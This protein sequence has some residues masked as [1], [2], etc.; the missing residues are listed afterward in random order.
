MTQS[1]GG[2][3]KHMTVTDK[4]ASIDQPV[5]RLALLGHRRSNDI[6]AW[7]ADEPILAHAFLAEV[8]CLARLLPDAR[9]MLNGC[10]DR[11]RFAVAMSAALVR[12]QISVLPHNHVASTLSHLASEFKGI[13][14]LTDS[15]DVYPE[16]IR[17]RYPM[18]PAPFTV[19]RQPED[20]AIESLPDYD[21]ALI[22][23]DQVAACLFT[24]GS[25]GA[26]VAHFRRWGQIVESAQLEAR[27]LALAVP[28][29]P[30]ILGTV[31][32]QHSYGFESTV[33]LALQAGWSFAAERPFF[34]ADILGC[35]ARLPRP[36]VLVTTPVHLRALLGI[37]H[38]RVPADLVL[39]AT[40]VLPGELAQSV[41]ALFSAPVHE[42]YGSTE[43]GQ[44][45]SR[46]TL[47]GDEWLPLDGITIGEQDG[48]AFAQ[49]AHV[50]GRMVLSDNIGLRAGGRFVLLGR[51]VDMVNIAGKRSSISFLEHQL[52]GIDGVK[53][54]AFLVTEDPS[55]VAARVLA[56]V[57]APGL[58]AEYI[59][60]AL[61][62]RIEAVFLPRPLLMVDALP[63]DGNGKLPR[64]RLE[65]LA[66]D[67]TSNR[68]E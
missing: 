1:Q 31:P 47:D 48:H 60:A 58:T 44:V 12:G 13:Y 30:A 19:D 32:A 9:Y 26:P 46:R 43:S 14:C 16:L 56:F 18:Q 62:A 67:L 11:Y 7:R 52:L 41:E 27:R 8:H 10:T 65:A 64:Q 63:R 66:R 2:N 38:N 45:A 50:T 29:R 53:D 34:P 39:S 59:T 33:H 25:T 21:T 22:A 20:Q 5:A 40:A 51:S 4:L 55:K 3:S 23:S 37:E 24:S 42:I 15:E 54:G 28:G 35:L 36:R 49:G 57:V 6:V 68:S 17:V 61:R